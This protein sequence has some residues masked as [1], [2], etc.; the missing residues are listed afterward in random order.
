MALLDRFERYAHCHDLPLRVALGVVFITAGFGKLFGQP[1]L[2]GFQ[3]MLQ[4]IG[5]PLAGMFALLV[6]V[7]E[8]GGAIALFLGLYTRYAAALLSVILIVAIIT[9]KIPGDGGLASMFTDIGLL[10]ASI[11]LLFTGAKTYC[12]DKSKSNE[13]AKH[14]HD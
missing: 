4:G 9:V 2:A 10:G 6:A 7:I 14:F 3:G 5:F 13:A 12:L 11:S 1:G 8:F